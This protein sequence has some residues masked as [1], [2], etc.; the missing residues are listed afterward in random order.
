[1]I[2]ITNQKE[3]ILITEKDLQEQLKQQGWIYEENDWGKKTFILECQNNPITTKQKCLYKQCQKTRKLGN[4]CWQH[5]DYLNNKIY[6]KKFLI[7]SSKIQLNRTIEKSNSNTYSIPSIKQ[8]L[9]KYVNSNQSWIDPFAGDGDIADVTNDI[10][11]NSK[12]HYHIDA[13]EF[14]RQYAS[15]SMNGI[16]LNP[17]YSFHQIY[18]FKKNNKTINLS[19]IDAIY[20]QADRLLKKNGLLIHFGWNSNGLGRKYGYLIEE[21]LI[22]ARGKHHNDLIVT[23]ERKKI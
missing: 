19:P 17:P 7:T 12:A 5:T 13:L 4:Y 6:P 23:V 11:S 14:L 2:K 8:L 21:I 3:T 16:L 20:K 18:T 10:D 22:V 9:K 1:M 15:N